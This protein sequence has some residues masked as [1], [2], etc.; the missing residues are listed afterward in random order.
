MRA[1]SNIASNLRIY[2]LFFLTASHKP[3]S[4]LL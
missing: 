2:L 1:V 3:L 4:P